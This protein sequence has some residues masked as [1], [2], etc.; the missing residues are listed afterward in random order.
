[1]HRHKMKKNINLVNVGFEV[2]GSE[3]EILPAQ[4]G[5]M[6]SFSPETT[7]IVCQSLGLEYS[8]GLEF[9]NV[10]IQG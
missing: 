4:G 9:T 6:F 8:L 1:M 2:L 3:Q 10:A 7:N 5:W